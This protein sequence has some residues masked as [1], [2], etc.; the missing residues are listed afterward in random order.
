MPLRFYSK[1]RVQSG[2]YLDN[3]EFSKPKTQT[4]FKKVIGLSIKQFIDVV[5]LRSAVNSVVEGRSKRGQGANIAVKHQYF[6]Q[7]HLAKSFN[8]TLGTTPSKLTRDQI[9]MPPN[10]P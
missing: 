2:T 9:I 3:F 4:T 1:R 10:K 8:K 6:D 5:R 7:S